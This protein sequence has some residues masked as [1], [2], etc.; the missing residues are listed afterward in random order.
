MTNR[1]LPPPPTLRQP[2]TTLSVLYTLRTW[3]LITIAMSCAIA[4]DNI[5]VYTL[6]S[7]LIGTL[8]Y[9]LNILGHDGLH[10]SLTTNK[11]LNNLICRLFLHG[12]QCA[13]LALLRRNHLLHHR[14]LGS[15]Q[16]PD[17]NYYRIDRFS[18]PRALCTWLSLAFIGGNTFPLIGKLLGFRK[19]SPTPINANIDTARIPLQTLLLD[20]SSIALSQA[21]IAFVIYKF[22]GSLIYY[23]T[24]WLMPIFSIMFGL[25]TLRSCL[26]HAEID[27]DHTTAPSRYNS[28]YSNP[29]ERF[30]LSPFSMNC[31]AEHHY[32][33]TIPF[34]RLISARGELR[35]IEK[36]PVFTTKTTYHSSYLNRLAGILEG[37]KLKTFTKVSKSEKNN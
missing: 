11:W 36:Y 20:F 21:T 30:F 35:N 25:N 37:Y 34:H 33:P 13:P 3:G 18:S 6:A 22:S 26:E 2:S 9:H 8:Q 23:F 28:F 24:L 16:D 10:Y 1:K 17:Q 29:V 4:F 19:G 7:L 31:H 12:P 14:L 15:T 32:W 27:I 5:F